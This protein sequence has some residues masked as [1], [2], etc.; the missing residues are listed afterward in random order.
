MSAGQNWYLGKLGV[1]GTI[2][3][4]RA[5]TASNISLGAQ[6]GVV[7]TLPIITSTKHAPS[8]ADGD[9]LTISAV[10]Q[11]TNSGAVAISGGS[12][13]YSKSAAGADSFTYTVSD[14][15]G[16]FATNTV[17]V[18]VTAVVNQQTAQLSFNGSGNA[19]LVFWG[20]PGTS[21]TIQK[22]SNL[23][24]WTDLTTVSANDTN[25]QPYGRISFTDTG[26]PSGTAGYYRLKP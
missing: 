25:T 24:T 16:G 12:V 14:G 5:P 15:R 8:D 11:G 19:V 18:N 3:V 9:T 23:S 22:S 6:A 26:A 13:T 2:A 4:N 17:T 7:Q 1:N 10:T 20:V 21:Y